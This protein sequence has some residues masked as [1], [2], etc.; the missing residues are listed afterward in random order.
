LKTLV[1]LAIAIVCFAG[2]TGAILIVGS[3]YQKVLFDEYLEDIENPSKP[4]SETYPNLPKI[5][6]LQ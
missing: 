2:I 1:I 3:A 4:D 6:I 5:D